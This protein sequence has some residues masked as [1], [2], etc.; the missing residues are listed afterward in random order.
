MLKALIPASLL[1]LSLGA[2]GFQ[3]VRQTRQAQIEQG[4]YLVE[5]VAMCVQCHTP[6]TQDGELI[7]SELLKGAPIPVR[8]PF[9]N[10]QWA[11]QAPNIAGMGAWSEAEVIRFLETG[12]R[13]NGTRPLPPMPPFRMNEKDAR[14]I[15]AFLRSL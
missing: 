7:R 6:R 12:L 11:I 14:A 9:P 8:S 13:P 5:N 4:R 15:A 2:G 3:A 1:L 10:R